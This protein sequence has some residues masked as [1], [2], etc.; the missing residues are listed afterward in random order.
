MK[1]MRIANRVSLGVLLFGYG[2]SGDVSPAEDPVNASDEQ[3]VGERAEPVD[4]RAEP[5][6]TAEEKAYV[7]EQLAEAGATLPDSVFVGRTLQMGDA[8]LDLEPILERR[9]EKGRVVLDAGYITERAGGELAFSRPQ[10][11]DEVWLVVPQSLRATFQQAVRDI[12]NVSAN[13]CLGPD[14]VNIKSPGELSDRRASE[15]EQTGQILDFGI[16]VTQVHADVTRCPG[17]A[18]CADFPSTFNVTTAPPVPAIGFLGESERVFGLGPNI[19]IDPSDPNLLHLVTHEL[20]HSL[21]L[22][23]TREEIR[24]RKGLIPGTQAGDDGYLSIM[25]ARALVD[26]EGNFVRDA[27]GNLIA[28]PDSSLTI[29]VDDADAIATLYAPPCDLGPRQTYIIQSQNTCFNGVC[30]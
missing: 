21:G 12:A 7:S 22:G 2:C 5:G 18:G 19:S 27:A 6:L 28:N 23:H 14:F 25:H 15:V 26:A 4:E 9:E 1:C 3:L 13:D 8:F 24:F 10:A 17:L 20:L 11:G 16:M 30:Q 29:S